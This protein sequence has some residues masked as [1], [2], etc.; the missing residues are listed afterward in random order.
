MTDCLVETTYWSP[1]VDVVLPP[2]KFQS[3]N[4]VNLTAGTSNPDVY[5]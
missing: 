4:C 1:K 2:I 5:F 3:V